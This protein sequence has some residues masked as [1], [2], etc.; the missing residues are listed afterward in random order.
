[1]NDPSM[2]ALPE[3]DAVML[4]GGFEICHG[5]DAQFPETDFHS[6]DHY[7]FY[8]FLDG[9]VTYYIEEQIYEL[10]PGDLLI[11]PPGTMHRPM[12]KCNGAVYER[13]VLGVN[14]DFLRMLQREQNEILAA[15]HTFRKKSGYRISLSGKELV[16]FSQLCDHLIQW[17]KAPVQ[18]QSSFVSV[19]L[20]SLLPCLS[21]GGR[22]PEVR[23]DLVADVIR[24]LN[25]HFREPIT[26]DELCAKF[27][28]SKYYLLRKFKSYTGTTIHDYLLSKRVTLARQLIRHGMS[29][30]DAGQQCGFSDYSNF[31]RTF[32]AKTGVTP[33]Q[34]KLRCQ[35]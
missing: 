20:H 24:Y 31:Y 28:V 1:M 32:T 7:E 12:V 15:L 35:E 13:I 3:T 11:I 6:H 27:F 34:F 2:I 30:G 14:I 26:L 23:T 17:T 5:R 9:N 16:F 10:M 8:L 19:Y 4:A 33:A 21:R 18:T 22:A 29:A 25:D